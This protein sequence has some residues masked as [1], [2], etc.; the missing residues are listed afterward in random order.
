MAAIK[1]RFPDLTI[2]QAAQATRNFCV[3]AI[4]KL[5]ISN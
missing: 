3:E 2:P 4:N 5:A 1:R